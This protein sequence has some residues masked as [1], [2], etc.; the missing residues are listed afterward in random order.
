M[1]VGCVRCW[2]DVFGFCVFGVILLVDFV[3]LTPRVFFYGL[4]LCTWELQSTSA[5]LKVQLAPLSCCSQEI[6]SFI[7]RQIEKGI[8]KRWS[9]ARTMNS[10]IYYFRRFSSD[11]L[12]W[13]PHI[14]GCNYYRVYSSLEYEVATVAL[15]FRFVRLCIVLASQVRSTSTVTKLLYLCWR[16][17]TWTFTGWTFTG[18]WNLSG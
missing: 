7:W 5:R 14:S 2:F 8:S 1:L 4:Y 11:Q 18:R 3:Q 6:R 15:S 10:R 13:Q 17:V 16:Q 12:P 9:H